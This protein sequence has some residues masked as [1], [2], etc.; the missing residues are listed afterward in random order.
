MTVYNDIRKALEEK[1]ITVS[2]ITTAEVAWENVPYNPDGKALWVR[3][4]LQVVSQRAATLGPLPARRDDGMLMVDVFG[5]QNLGP[6]AV[7]SLVDGILTAFYPGTTLS[8]GGNK[9]LRILSSQRSLGRNDQPWYFV[10]MSISFY[11]YIN[12]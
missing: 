6:G 1:I 4:T 2:G 12:E 9:S 8:A 5:S 7:D 3:P 10:P 11:T